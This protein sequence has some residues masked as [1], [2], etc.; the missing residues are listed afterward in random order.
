MKEIEYNNYND[1]QQQQQQQPSNVY[2][3]LADEK[4][5]D[6]HFISSLSPWLNCNTLKTIACVIESHLSIFK[7]HLV[8]FIHLILILLIAL[9]IVLCCLMQVVQNFINQVICE[10]TF[11]IKLR[12]SLKQYFISRKKYEQEDEDEDAKVKEDKV[13]T[14]NEI[15]KQEEEEIFS[16]I[17]NATSRQEAINNITSHLNLQVNQ[18]VS[19][20]LLAKEPFIYQEY[21][22]RYLA[23]FVNCNKEETKY[24]DNVQVE[25]IKIIYNNRSKNVISSTVNSY[26]VSFKC[27]EKSKMKEII[28]KLGYTITYGCECNINNCI[29]MINGV[30]NTFCDTTG[31]KLYRDLSKWPVSSTS[32]S[33]KK[34][35]GYLN[36]ADT[37]V[38][39]FSWLKRLFALIETAHMTFA[40]LVKELTRHLY[41]N[42]NRKPRSSDLLF[43]SNHRGQRLQYFNC[44]S[45]F[46][47]L[48]CKSL[49]LAISDCFPAD[50]M[51][52]IRSATKWTDDE[53]AITL[54]ASGIKSYVQVVT[55]ETP[56]NIEAFLDSPEMA[57][58][59][60]P[61]E[62]ADDLLATGTAISQQLRSNSSLRCDLKSNSVNKLPKFLT[63]CISK[64]CKSKN[65]IVFKPIYLN[66]TSTSFMSRSFY[67]WSK[68]EDENFLRFDIIHSLDSTVI[69]ISGRKEVI[70]SASLLSE[71]IAKSLLNLCISLSISY[72]RR[73]PP[74]SP[75]DT[76]RDI[77]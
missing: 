15:K 66:G 65:Q 41:A 71:C 55:G 68:M 47:E 76:T 12:N 67:S 5:K 42:W 58:F 22:P 24:N 56:S 46:R 77:R 43:T 23:F 74:S 29:K 16:V 51:A 18:T 21:L 4:V 50:L 19:Y 63:K 10:N 64:L 3:N 28:E 20:T 38:K 36:D 61:L 62:S 57:H 73:T 13:V 9:L 39:V 30:E 70:Q 53:I 60:L 40:T 37:V 11:F 72:D 75:Q 32:M 8:I 17:I 14:S 33:E 54:I 44:N 31:V 7:V 2:N 26:L 34:F 45:S 49:T 52:L 27:N 6:L 59:I 1:Q 48:R 35:T 69:C 25:I